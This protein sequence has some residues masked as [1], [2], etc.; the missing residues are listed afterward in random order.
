MS[1]CRLRHPCQ[2]QIESRLK[3]SR[4]RASSGWPIYRDCL[5]CSRCP[6]RS[7]LRCS[8]CLRCS[9][10]LDRPHK[11]PAGTAAPKRPE[12][13]EISCGVLLQAACSAALGRE[14]R[15]I[16]QLSRAINA[17]LRVIALQSDASLRSFGVFV[18]GRCRY[19]FQIA[20]RSH[21]D[22]VNQRC[23]ALPDRASHLRHDG[24]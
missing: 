21:A 18:S 9:S 7:C 15:H 8:R 11:R 16:Q 12:G 6:G 17:R 23:A 5:R 10:C 22:C 1:H 4:C 13:S 20:I 3:C 24:S 14:T 19:S 2:S